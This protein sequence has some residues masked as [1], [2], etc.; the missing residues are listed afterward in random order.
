MERAT[1]EIQKSYGFG[2]S[3]QN[4]NVRKILARKFI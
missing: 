2:L 1:K 3:V 4:S